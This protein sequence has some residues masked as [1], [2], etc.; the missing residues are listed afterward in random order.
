MRNVLVVVVLP[1]ISGR[2][3]RDVERLEV[4]LARAAVRRTSGGKQRGPCSKV[5]PRDVREPPMQPRGQR[6][7]VDGA[8]V[9]EDHES[10]C[11]LAVAAQ[12]F[13]WPGS[14]N[15]RAIGLPV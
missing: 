6:G 8:R 12:M 7:G 5:G 15:G 11:C 2:H 1:S 9:V 13:T 14:P 3:H 4:C 10:A